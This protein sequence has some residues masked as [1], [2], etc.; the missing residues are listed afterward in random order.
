MSVRFTI[1][2]FLINFLNEHLALA[3]FTL[4][5][6]TLFLINPLNEQLYFRIGY[7]KTLRINFIMVLYNLKLT[8]KFLTI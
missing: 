4:I 5:T 8:I 7:F 6:L 1:I 2:F 3:L